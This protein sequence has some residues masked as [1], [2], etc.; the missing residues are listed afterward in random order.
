MPFDSFDLKV[1]KI[2]KDEIIPE[3]MDSM[4]DRE[5]PDE[6]WLDNCKIK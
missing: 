2:D 3:R 6:D 5:I 1:L 4:D